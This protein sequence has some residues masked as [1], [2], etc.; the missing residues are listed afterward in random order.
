MERRHEDRDGF[1]GSWP[2]QSG[3]YEAD[4]RCWCTIAHAAPSLTD[5]G[6]EM[7]AHGETHSL[8]CLTNELAP[9]TCWKIAW[10]PLHS[11]LR[12]R[13]KPLQADV[14]FSEFISLFFPGDFC[15]N[16]FD[17]CAFALCSS[18]CL[19][20]LHAI[21][22]HSIFCLL[23]SFVLVGWFRTSCGMFFFLI[24]YLKLL[25]KGEKIKDF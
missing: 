24:K 12:E 7:S 15:S 23:L 4:G 16:R 21:L 8:P 10:K 20:C 17:F 5:P 1:S 9:N 25:Q 22:N 13:G 2:K 3:Q 11:R 18:T 14:L 6:A 19:F